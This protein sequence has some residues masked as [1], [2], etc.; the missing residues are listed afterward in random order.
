MARKEELGSKKISVLLRELAIPAIFAMLVTLLYNMVDRIY[1]GNMENG[2]VGMAGLAIAVP[3][4]TLIQAF[5]MMFGTGGAPLSAI[6]LGEN[7]KD[8]AER[9]MCTSFSTLIIV[10]VILTFV[11]EL[12][13]APILMMF[14]ADAQT[15]Q[16]AME[17]ITIYAL[18]TVF[19]QITQG[20]NAYINTQG[21]AKTGMCTVL[22]GALLNIV[23]DPIFIF[24]F[25]MGIKG[26]ALATILSQ[27]VS[28]AWVLHFLVKQSPMKLRKEFLKPDLKVLGS[29]M[30]LGVSPFIMNSTESLL[31]ISFNNQLTQFGGGMAVGTM[32]ILLSLYQMINMPIAGICQGAQPILSYNYGAKNYDRVRDTFKLTFKVCMAYSLTAASLILIFS[33]VFARVFSSD[34][35]TVEFASWAIRIYLFG[36]LIFGAQLV[37]QQSFMALGQAKR[38]LMMALLRKVILLIPLIYI[39]PNVLGDSAFAAQMGEPVAHL[40]KDG[41]RTFC[42]FFAEPVADITA[43]TITTLTFMQFYKTALMKK[44]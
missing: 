23:L 15:L 32:A 12:F 28:A 37:C 3:V 43:A 21:F 5:T 8:G 18:G 31:Q 14:G 10:G 17:Y 40:A 30:M 34:A 26:A 36:G 4:I 44:E 2:T 7:D 25:D 16:P 33:P 11:I 42:V 22:I 19:V 35:S 1:I 20:M 41:A 39:L 6:K 13:Q 38:S 29:I 24:M 27:A 9:I